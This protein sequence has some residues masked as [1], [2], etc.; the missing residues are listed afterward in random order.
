MIDERLK[1]NPGGAVPQTIGREELQKLMKREHAQLVEVLPPKQ[2]HDVHL[3]S[4][5]NLPLQEFDAE[6]VVILQKNRP[7]IVY[8]YDHQ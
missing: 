7:V 1:G 8:C 2:Y 4:A 5:I 6:A 3:L